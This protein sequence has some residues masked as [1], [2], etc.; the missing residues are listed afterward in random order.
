[1][2]VNPLGIIAALAAFLSIWL[3]HVSVR[4][5]EAHTVHLWKPMVTL[6]AL[7]AAMLLAAFLFSLRP[8][9]LV[10]GIVGMT[11]LW[12]VLELRRQARRVSMGH[13][14]VNLKNPRHA[15]MLID[16]DLPVDGQKTGDTIP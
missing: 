4:I 2:Q 9:S 14:P 11:L 10:C 3:G 13:S 7:G 5:I 12:D 1:M 6:A 15:A 8:L 16:N